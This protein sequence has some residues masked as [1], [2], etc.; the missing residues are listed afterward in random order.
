ML[1]LATKRLVFPVL[2]GVISLALLVRGLGYYWGS[3][4]HDGEDLPSSVMFVAGSAALVAAV[5]SWGSA[6]RRWRSLWL[7]GICVAGVL[8]LMT[9]AWWVFNVMLER[10][11]S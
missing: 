8:L 11:A 10:W 9:F 7:I 5:L 2:L 6:R 4:P 1:S 3:G